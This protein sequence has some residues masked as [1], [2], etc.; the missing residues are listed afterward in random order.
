MALT[1]WIGLSWVGSVIWSVIIVLQLSAACIFYAYMWELDL[2]VFLL[3]N[4]DNVFILLPHIIAH[5][6]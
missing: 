2:R 4:T 5:A 6:K 1:F 3:S